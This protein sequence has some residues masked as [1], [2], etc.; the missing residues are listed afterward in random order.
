MRSLPVYYIRHNWKE[1]E[2]QTIIN[3]LFEDHKVGIH[4]ENT[5]ENQKDPFDPN[6]YHERAGKTSINCLN[7]CNKVESLIVAAYKHHDKILIGKSETSSKGLFFSND[8]EIKYLKL[9]DFKKVTID[10][11][12]LPFLIAP[13]FSTF[14]KWHMGKISVNTFFFKKEKSFKIEM[15]LP[16]QLE[17]LAEEWL[18][19]KDIIKYK[20]YK[21]GGQMKS[22][23][24]VGV[25]DENNPIYVQVKHECS[26]NTVNKFFGEID[27]MENVKGYFFT[28][29]I[30][31]K[32]PDK[33]SDE[34]LITF[35]EVINDFRNDKKYL[36]KLCYGF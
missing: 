21:T 17:I 22:F 16:W 24:I 4:F 18:R 7:E 29:K 12:P 33:I 1:E 11:F 28:I 5:K 27:S 31:G 35:K 9:T 15:L 26:E 19:K 34:G 30:I 13:P 14:V 2:Y 36:E 10:A 8:I 6:S 32:V 25:D 3:T 23:D 20:L